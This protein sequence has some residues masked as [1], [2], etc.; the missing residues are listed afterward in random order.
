[1]ANS[2]DTVIETGMARGEEM[3]QT[4]PRGRAVRYDAQADRVI[5]D[6]VNDCVFMFPPRLVQG[7]SDLPAEDIADVTL[8]GM[9]VMLSWDRPD[10]QITL[11][12][13]MAGI[14]GTKAYMQAELARKAGSAK[15]DAKAK[16]ARSNGAKGGRPR[17]V[18]A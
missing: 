6:L 17:K 10:V 1:M 15:S 13:L 2:L 9:G 7:L 18:A 11:D 12:G 5:V 14:F 3:L 4:K 8:L 16:A